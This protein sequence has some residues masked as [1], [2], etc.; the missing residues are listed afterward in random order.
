MV[1]KKAIAEE[2]APKRSL[3]PK[4]NPLIDEEHS[5]GH[6]ILVERRRLGQTNL[7]VKVGQ[8]GIANASKPANLGT[9]DYA[10]LRV[11]LPKDLSGSGIFLVAKQG[12]WPESYFLMRRSSDG[13]I[14]ATGMFKA[15]FPWASSLE[16][17]AE[18]K[19]HKEMSSAIGSEEVAGSVW[20]APDEALELSEEYGLRLWVDALLSPE[21]IEKGSKDKSINQIMTP[22]KASR[23]VSP[24]KIAT[25]SRKMAS[26]R[27]SRSTRSSAKADTT[28][29]ET[30]PS[31]LSN[32]L[33]NGTSESIVSESVDEEVAKLEV[34]NTVETNGEGEL[35]TTAIKFDWPANS[36]T[37]PLPESPEEMIAKAQAMV[38]EANKLDA[39]QVNGVKP[40]KRKV[41][42]V[43]VDEEEAAAAAQPTKKVKKLEE[44]AKKDTVTRKALFGTIALAAIGASIPYFS[45]YFL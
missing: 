28:K 21:P 5:P 1:S 10:H 12:A 19:H 27:K 3:P 24:S 31:N 8:V 36:P 4:R 20:I 22:P 43:E 34:T 2:A 26:P 13:F 9:F 30:A 32:V 42:E 45:P 18:R 40:S 33:E 23:S 29:S 15:A 14:S 39:K 37:L 41:D 38:E 11:P 17:E 35:A 7:A 16:E 6:E 44:Q 25:P